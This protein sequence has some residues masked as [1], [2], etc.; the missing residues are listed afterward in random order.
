MRASDNSEL[1][2]LVRHLAFI[3]SRAREDLTRTYTE[4][5]AASSKERMYR[6]I[7]S[8]PAIFILDPMRY[9]FADHRGPTF[10]SCP[11]ERSI[12]Q[13]TDLCSYHLTSR[14]EQSNAE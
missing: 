12:A 7:T 1:D 13:I 4:L 6:R 14:F 3:P 11:T 2:W 10:A 9:N 5:S 8:R